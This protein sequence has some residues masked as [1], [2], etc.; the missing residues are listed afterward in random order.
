LPSN[1]AVHNLSRISSY[2]GNAEKTI[3]KSEESD[4]FVSV[5]AG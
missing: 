4:M 1:T 2:S 5:H 3:K